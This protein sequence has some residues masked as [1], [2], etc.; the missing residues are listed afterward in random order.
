MDSKC[1]LFDLHNL[2]YI[3]SFLRWNLF[4]IDWPMLIFQLVN[5]TYFCFL[6]FHWFNCRSFS[7]RLIYQVLIFWFIQ[8]S[9]IFISNLYFS[10][11]LC[12]FKAHLWFIMFPYF[13]TITILFSNWY[14]QILIPYFV[15]LSYDHLFQVEASY[16]YLTIFAY[17]T[18]DF[19]DF[20]SFLLQVFWF[21]LNQFQNPHFM[22]IAY[23]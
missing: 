17:S 6:N 22:K 10:A 18:F 2:F 19:L 12:Y 1:L 15:N 13:K 7:R 11:I 3:F 23:F 21:Q 20:S 16:K 8:K 14:P 4:L 9:A 5:L